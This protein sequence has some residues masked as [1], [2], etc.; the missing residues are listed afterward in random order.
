MWEEE[1]EG[2]GREEKGERDERFRK[3]V[4]RFMI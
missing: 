4:A 1:R 3:K 2:K